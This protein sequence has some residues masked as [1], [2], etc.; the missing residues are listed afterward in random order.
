MISEIISEKKYYTA[1]SKMQIYEDIQHMI[2]TA[3]SMFGK[4]EAKK[5]CVFTISESLFRLLKSRPYHYELP[6]SEYPNILFGFEYY[7]NKC[8]SS[9][10]GIYRIG[11][12]LRNS[13]SKFLNIY[14]K[15]ID[16]GRDRSTAIPT[17]HARFGK[18]SVDKYCIKKVIFND[19]ATIVIWSDESKTIVK[20]CDSDVFDPEKGL[21]MAVMKKVYG[22]NFHKVIKEWISKEEKK[23]E[24]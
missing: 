13:D 12:T 24:S 7:I 20:C 9:R 17:I 4:T 22:D 5:G 14:K 8:D 21:A 18:L 1:P 11:M 15:Y 16:D 2:D 3:I 10:F 6:I 23:E 19:P